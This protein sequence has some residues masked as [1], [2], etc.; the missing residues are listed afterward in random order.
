M[1]KMEIERKLYSV[2]TRD[3]YDKTLYNPKT[4]ALEIGNLV[5]PIRNSRSIYGRWLHGGKRC[6]TR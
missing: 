5:L 2:T 1:K 6:K 4:T 3:E